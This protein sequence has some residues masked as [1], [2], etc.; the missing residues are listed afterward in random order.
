V[1]RSPP[2]PDPEATWFL[3][4]LAD[5]VKGIRYLLSLLEWHSTRP[6]RGRIFVDGKEATMT[7]PTAP[8]PI[9]DTDVPFSVVWDDRF[10][11]V[12]D[13]SADT[14]WTAVDDKGVATTVVTPTADATDQQKG[15]LSFAAGA[16][17]FQLVAETDG[18]SGKIQAKSVLYT[19]T[20]G[21]PAVGA[22]S[23]G[24]TA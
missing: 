14:T 2:K 12:K 8:T 19:I 3:D 9:P 20:P 10:E 13:E 11:D 17:L 22:I 5:A 7:S 6:V 16:G 24:P 23:V 15:T 21:A 1:N 18:V 4:L